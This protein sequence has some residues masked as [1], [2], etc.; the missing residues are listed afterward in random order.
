MNTSNHLPL[1]AAAFSLAL[2]AT[3]LPHG[4]LAADS[5]SSVSGQSATTAPVADTNTLEIATGVDYSVGHYGATADTSVVSVPIDL[6]AQLGK[7][8]L[9]A[10]LPYVFLNG[11]GQLVGGVIVNNP[12]N[13]ATVKRDGIGDVSLSAAYLLT[14][15]SG[16]L[17]SVEIGGGVK[18]PTA[19]TTIGTGETDFS[20]SLSAYKS[21]SQQLM[22]FGS[23]G[24]SWLGSP[25][26]YRLQN[27]ITAS[28]GLNLRPDQNQ[29]YGVSVA[30]RE[31]VAAGLEG[32]AVV[33]PYM[34]Y[35]VSKTFGLTLYGMGGLNNASPRWG[36]GLRFSV[37]K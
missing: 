5:P 36:A 33:S 32:Q 12:G 14:T 37:F 15:E 31:P 10:S 18:L 13:T 30:W 19:K 2:A 28:G 8:R 20:A 17:P 9:Q 34:T 25:T 16:M 6:K 27:G 29:N 1:K 22:L 24:Y 3:A 21:L 4:A 11:P 23:V 35:R 7:L 26:T